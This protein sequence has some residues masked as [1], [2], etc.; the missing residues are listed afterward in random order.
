M[1][2][3]IQLFD[4]KLKISFRFDI[5]NKADHNLCFDSISKLNVAFYFIAMCT[6]E[7]STQKRFIF[8]PY[9]GKKEQ[10]IRFF[11]IESKKRIA[12]V[13]KKKKR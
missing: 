1:S 7:K 9:K 13:H 5:E 8:Q 6:K 10:I 2:E 12:F 4:L 11:M 3:R